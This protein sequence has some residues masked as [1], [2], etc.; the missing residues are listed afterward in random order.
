MIHIL[1]GQLEK[2]KRDNCALW[3]RD[4]GTGCGII[5]IIIIKIAN[6]IVNKGPSAF[7]YLLSILTIL[8]K[9]KEVLNRMQQ[10]RVKM[11]PALF[12]D[13]TQHRVIVSHQRFRTKYLLTYLLTHSL[14]GA[15]SFLRS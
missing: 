5:T 1:E 8:G 15:E 13:F 7:T 3:Y 10:C 14:H 11:S 4:Y 6:D 9:C 12:W 2:F